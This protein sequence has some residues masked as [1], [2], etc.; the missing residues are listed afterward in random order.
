MADIPTGPDRRPSSPAGNNQLPSRIW[1]DLQAE[2]ILWDGD[3]LLVGGA[4]DLPARM[5]VTR[6][7]MTLV[8]NGEI[9]LEAPP[10]WLR[11]SPRLAAENGIRLYITP[12][13]D[14]T[15]TEPILMRTPAGRGAAAELVAIL[16]GKPLPEQPAGPAVTIP[17]W[18]DKIGA[19]PAIALPTLDDDEPA[20]ARTTAA[21]PPVED[22]GVVARK[23]PQPR[24]QGRPL[25]A[26]QST[27]NAPE[28]GPVPSSISRE[29]RK[30]GTRA[31]GITI[32]DEESAV[33]MVPRRQQPGR[34]HRVATWSLWAAILV[35]LV[36]TVG[37]FERD[38]LDG[39]WSDIQARIPVDIQ[40]SLGI[41]D[42]TPGNDVAYQEAPETGIAGEGGN[43][44]GDGTNGA[45]TDEPDVEEVPVETEVSEPEPEPS[46]VPDP[47]LDPTANVG[48]ATGELPPTN[49]ASEETGGEIDEPVEEPAPTEA[50]IEEPAPTEPPVVEP[51]VAP[52]PTAEPTLAPT[53]AP[54]PTAVPTEEPEPTAVPTEEPEPTAVPTEEPEP[55]VEPT[56]APTEEPEPTVAPTEEPTIEPTVEPTEASTPEPTE[57]PVEE[58]TAEPTP[59]P[60]DVPDVTAP[61]PTEEPVEEPEP[62]P[63]LV[64]QEPS[65]QPETTPEQAIVSG[66]FRYTVEGASVGDTVPELPEINS[67]GGYGEWVVLSMYGQ[68][69]SDEAQVFDMSDFRLFADGQ[70][71]YVDVGNAWVAGMLGNTPAYGN[72]DAIQWAPGEGN[73]FTLTFLAPPE[74]QSLVLQAGDQTI[75]LSPALVEPEPLMDDGE[76]PAESDL[77]QAQVVEVIDAETIVIEVDGVRQTVRYLGVDVPTGDACYAAEAAEANRALVEGQTVILERQA[78]DVD[79]RG[80]WVRDVWV[81]NEAG[82]PVLASQQLVASGAAEADI[83]HPNSRFAGWL[84]SSEAGA[85]NAGD[86]IWGACGEE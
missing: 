34:G 35:I 49:N 12:D 67:V 85:R 86:G 17:N 77:L 76:V 10:E 4:H 37:Y 9:A 64:P 61:E 75:D 16:S 26:W 42:D 24:P 80:N 59:E 68:N 81:T 18:K 69:M 32:N 71:V 55:T 29:A 66:G 38:R 79:A 31:D 44:T 51:T 14:A 6:R 40:R 22:D 3:I 46:E 21:W 33:P 83:S 57:A 54:E 7:R 58:P 50:P 78:T 28:P 72:T 27:A 2:T 63:T 20:S 43:A 15:A 65:V 73:R 5:I 45:T 41:G 47:D 62:T 30:Q 13:G 74:A 19:A 8:M 60:T 25:S 48:G 82:E 53:E 36:G 11:P 52:E 84:E 70:E 56:A 23:K 1:H 39:A